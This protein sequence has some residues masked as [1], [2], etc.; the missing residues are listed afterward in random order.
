MS[1]INAIQQLRKGDIKVMSHVE[2]TDKGEGVSPACHHAQTKNK[3]MLEYVWKTFYSDI[4]CVLHKTGSWGTGQKRVGIREWMLIFF[5]MH[6][7]QNFEQK[8]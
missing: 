8:Y 3:T 2:E 5:G 6:Y 7:I 4:S 1:S